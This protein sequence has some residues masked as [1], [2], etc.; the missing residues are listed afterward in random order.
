MPFSRVCP[1]SFSPSRGRG[2]AGLFLLPLLLAL[3]CALLWPAAARAAAFTAQGHWMFGV[4]AGNVY[5]QKR[6]DVRDHLQAVQRLRTQF[7]FDAAHGLSGQVQLEMGKTN[8]GEAATGGALGADDALTK[9]RHAWL[10]W[11]V[12]G[13]GASVRMGLQPVNMPSFVNGSPLFS[14]DAA[15]IVISQNLREN[16]DITAFWVRASA[17]NQ[18]PGT[19]KLPGFNE[20]DF[21]GLSL[22]LNGPS[23]RLTPYGMFANAGINSYGSRGRSATGWTLAPYK[24]SLR[25]VAANLTPVGGPAI[26]A[27]PGNA[28]RLRPWGSSWWGGLGGDVDLASGWHLAAE[29][30]GG[31]AD[32]GSLTLRGRNFAMR[33]AGFYAAFLAEYRFPALTPALL[34]WYSSGDDDDPWNGSERMPVGKSANRDWKV[35]NLAYDGAPFCPDGGAQILSPNGTMIGTWGLVASLKDLSLVPGLR[36]TLR[37]GYVR[38]TN[39]PGMVE[40][41]PFFTDTSPG[42]YLTT[43]DEALEV[44]V[45]T[46][47][48]LYKNLT[49][50]LDADWLRVNWDGSVWKRFGDRLTQDFYRVGLTAYYHF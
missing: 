44:D 7:G 6:A 46:R 40:N 42:G 24:S 20:L 29:A 35:L 25:T 34:G 19:D 28:R 2:R 21:F 27:D 13:S 37:A 36:H 23:F 18:N 41:D 4:N 8:W 10:D 5:G 33:R 43:R 38:G 22:P 47:L 12:P 49:L 31:S 26:L 16:L 14:E 15:A 32:F 39:A 1:A 3:A 17:D 48:E 50:I 45:E 9:L 30:A 11:R